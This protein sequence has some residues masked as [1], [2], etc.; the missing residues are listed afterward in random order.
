MKW[1]MT[2]TFYG[3]G[4]GKVYHYRNVSVTKAH[5]VGADGDGWVFLIHTPNG[6]GVFTGFATMRDAKAAALDAIGVTA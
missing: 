4:A 6:D 3:L 2:H 5:L 1:T